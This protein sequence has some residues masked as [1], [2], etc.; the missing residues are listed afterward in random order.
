MWVASG[1]FIPRDLQGIHAQ[2]VEAELLLNENVGVRKAA[3]GVEKGLRGGTA[4]Q[5]DS[6]NVRWNFVV[7]DFYFS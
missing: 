7:K 6:I 2:H 5:E 3:W 1:W 4:C